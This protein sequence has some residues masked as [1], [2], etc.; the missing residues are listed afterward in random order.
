MPRFEWEDVSGGC[1]VIVGLINPGIRTK[2]HGMCVG[3]RMSVDDTVNP[4]SPHVTSAAPC[5]EVT[6]WRGGL[7]RGSVIVGK[8]GVCGGASDS[9]DGEFGIREVAVHARGLN[10]G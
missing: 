3:S 7:V 4:R 8:E 1:G 9:E 6:G 2:D 5:R 10:D